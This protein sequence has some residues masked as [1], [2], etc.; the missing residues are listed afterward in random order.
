[1]A[2][3]KHTKNPERYVQILEP[4][5]PIWAVFKDDDG[6]DMRQRIFLVALTA[7]GIIE[8][9]TRDEQEIWGCA[10]DATNFVRYEYGKKK[11]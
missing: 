9:I 1:M 3:T 5:K 10:S 8:M 7:D 2:K 4:Q 11:T 6:T